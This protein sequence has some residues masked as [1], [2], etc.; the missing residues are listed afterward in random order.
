MSANAPQD[1]VH[2]IQ[3]NVREEKFVLGLARGQAAYTAAASAGYASP[4]H[5]YVLIRQPAILGLLR[6]MAA[7]LRHALS[8]AGR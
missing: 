4:C 3:M 6:T 7:N 2:E 5:A 8:V 1:A